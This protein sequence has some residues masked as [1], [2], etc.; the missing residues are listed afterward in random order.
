[1]TY[2]IRIISIL[3]L[4]I[5][6]AIVFMT[7]AGW[8]KLLIVKSG[9]MEPAIPINSII[10]TIPK[11]SPLA[12]STDYGIGDVIS[13]QRLKNQVPITHRIV[14]IKTQNNTLSYIVKGDANETVDMFSVSQKSVVGKS[15]V[16]L[17][18]IGLVPTFLAHPLG[19]ML[20]VIIPASIV[21]LHEVMVIH[22]EL[23]RS[24]SKFT[25]QTFG[26]E[27]KIGW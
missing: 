7:Y 10:L 11:A 15:V 1:M 14:D 27:T 17:P 16:W 2:S 19:L 25:T 21:I 22:G 6:A 12:F 18:Y 13:F 4:S 26:F 24:K 23:K 8:I 5:L 3:F 9:S 20:L